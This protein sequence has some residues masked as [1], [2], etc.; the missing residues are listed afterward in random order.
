MKV[1]MKSIFILLLFSFLGLNI[2][3]SQTVM[4]GNDSTTYS[5]R[6]DFIES[7]NFDRIHVRIK[8]NSKGLQEVQSVN[9][10]NYSRFMIDSC[11]FQAWILPYIISFRPRASVVPEKDG[12][13][14]YN[15][16]IILSIGHLKA[17]EIR[18]YRREFRVLRRKLGNVQFGNFF[19]F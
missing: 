12:A 16:S 3:Q 2:C 9:F 1:V 13:I 6:V 5:L 10:Q 14:I 15:G 19:N 7:I 8:L 4:Q 17:K 18:K 11:T